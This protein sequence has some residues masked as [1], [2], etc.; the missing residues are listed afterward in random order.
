MLP[1]IAPE[2]DWRLGDIAGATIF[3]NFADIPSG[4]VAFLTLRVA[5]FFATVCS[6]ITENLK[7]VG[8]GAIRVLQLEGSRDCTALNGITVK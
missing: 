7:T 5:S 4:L 3:N 1:E 2:R 8:R 6:E